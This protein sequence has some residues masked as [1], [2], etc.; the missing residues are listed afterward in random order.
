M[1]LFKKQEGKLRVAS[2]E[3]REFFLTSLP[4]DM[5]KLKLIILGTSFQARNLFRLLNFCDPESI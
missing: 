4:T 2:A 1:T 3:L 5:C